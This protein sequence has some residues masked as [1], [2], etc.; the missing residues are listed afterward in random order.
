MDDLKI[1]LSTWANKYYKYIKL[2]DF[3][4]EKKYY[5]LDC[6]ELINAK[7]RV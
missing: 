5:T 6:F 7:L 2:S 4:I 3:K 1:I